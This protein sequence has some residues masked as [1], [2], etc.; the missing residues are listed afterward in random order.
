MIKNIVLDVGKVLVQWDPDEAMRKLG[1]SEAERTAISTAMFDS[2]IWAETDRGVLNNE[3]LLNAFY[4][5]APSYQKQIKL[6]WD[7]INLAIWQFPYVK[8]WIRS[9]KETGYHVYIL[10]NYGEHTYFKTKE[11]GLDFLPLVDGAIFSYT[12]QMVKPDAKIYETLCECFDLVPEECVFIDDLSDNI[13]GA[14]AVGMQGIV[15]TG[16]YDALAELNK[17]GVE[18]AME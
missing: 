6:L 12:I 14:K 11:E 1:F 4:L 5:E 3:E 9:M 7:N 8:D 17:L 2:G 18:L 16:L 10:S 13:E 15:F